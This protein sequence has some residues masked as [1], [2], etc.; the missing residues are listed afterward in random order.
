MEVQEVRNYMV[1]NRLRPS[2]PH[3][4]LANV[5]GQCL[6]DMIQVNVLD[7][8]A[9]D[10]LSP[11]EH[12]SLRI[13]RYINLVCLPPKQAQPPP[14]KP[15]RLCAGIIPRG[16]RV[17]LCVGSLSPIPYTT[18]PLQQNVSIAE[19][20]LV[21]LAPQDPSGTAHSGTSTYLEN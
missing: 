15:S 5:T 6:R 3:C 2:A 14:P 12:D 1:I 7:L 20:S 10:W 9:G 11:K 13:T 4:C 17:L 18:W 16:S 21:S 8:Y 19:V